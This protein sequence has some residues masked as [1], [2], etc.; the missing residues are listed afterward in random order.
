M[1]AYGC[2]ACSLLQKLFTPGQNPSILYISI[3]VIVFVNDVKIHT[4]EATSLHYPLVGSIGYRLANSA[5]VMY[6]V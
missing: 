4:S 5:K 1:L 2:T 3:S 6:M